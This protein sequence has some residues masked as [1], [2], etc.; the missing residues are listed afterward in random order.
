MSRFF[1]ILCEDLQASCFLRRALIAAGAR[2]HDI[3]VCPFP[4]NRFRAQS[5]SDDRPV[6][7]YR[8]YACGS[9]H[10]RENYPSELV[11]IRARSA[12]RDAALVVH[13]DVDNSSTSE[14]TVQDRQRELEGACRARGVPARR[15][16]D[17]V[18]HIVPRRNIETWIH[19]LRGN[20]PID[21]AVEYPKW[22]GR[23]AEAAEAAVDFVARSRE[24]GAPL[25][26]PPSLA[27]GL[28]E[29]HRVL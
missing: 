16:S 22:G 2:R 5:A 11:A 29:F 6:D 7:G 8:V 25:G 12:K 3:R 9:Q 21:E 28:A 15:D 17:P 26:A 4:D 13:I 10:V 1:V 19:F 18:A 14:R 27:M 23:E 20:A 24:P